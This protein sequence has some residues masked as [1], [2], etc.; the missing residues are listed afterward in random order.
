[1]NEG[2]LLRRPFAM[3]RACFSSMALDSAFS[4]WLDDGQDNDGDQNEGGKLV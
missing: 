2:R 1:M 4:E 3:L